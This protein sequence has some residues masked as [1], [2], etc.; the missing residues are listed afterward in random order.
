MTRAAWDELVEGGV[1]PI[2]N[3]DW[4][5][6]KSGK[7]QTMARKKT[8]GAEMIHLHVFGHD[9]EVPKE[10]YAVRREKDSAWGTLYENGRIMR[11]INAIG[12]EPLVLIEKLMALA[13]KGAAAEGEVAKEY[14]A[15]VDRPMPPDPVAQAIREV[16]AGVVEAIAVHAFT[17]LS[18]QKSNNLPEMEKVLT[19]FA[20][21][22]REIAEKAGRG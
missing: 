3:A 12:P 19:A 17:L 1:A 5:L 7:G 14:E 20:N 9:E 8:K 2:A 21:N 15:T 13:Q 18:T 10:G 6:G 11:G 16:G 22:F 4:M